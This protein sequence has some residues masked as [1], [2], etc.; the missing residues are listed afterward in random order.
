MGFEKV[1]GIARHILRV[2]KAN[3]AGLDIVQIRKLILKSGQVQQHLDRRLRQLDPFF[4]IRR[5]RD[6]MRTVYKLIGKRKPGQWEYGSIDKT[7]RAKILTKAGGRCQMC[8]RTIKEDKITLH[9]DHKIP[10]SWGGLTT[11]ENLWCICSPCN[12]GKKNYF[13]S[14]DAGI[15][16]KIMGYDSVHN[17]IVELLH[18]KQAQWVG[19]DLIEFV[20]N[21]NDYQ[22]DWRKRLRELRYFGLNIEMRRKRVGRRSISE[23]KLLNWTKLPKNIG[24]AV[25][26]YESH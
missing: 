12:E 21:Y 14:M 4:V 3:R 15:M 23:Y 17:R 13:S 5:M 9:I 26:K 1:S 24:Q 6:G 7:L 11:P 25:G 8:G 22:T 10:Q 19:C 18:L 20:A 2:L 16:K